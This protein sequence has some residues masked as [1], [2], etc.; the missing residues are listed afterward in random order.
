MLNDIKDQKTRGPY[1][2]MK[3]SAFRQLFLNLID[4][5][6][7]DFIAGTADDPA[8]TFDAEMKR[9]KGSPTPAQIRN[10]FLGLLVKPLSE[11]S[12]ESINDLIYYLKKGKHSDL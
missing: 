3:Y 7:K 8:K 2:S 11:Y 12:K 5:S 10:N 1:G 6:S 9:N 4:R